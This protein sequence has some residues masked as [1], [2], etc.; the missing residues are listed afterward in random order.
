MERLDAGG[1]RVHLQFLVGLPVQG[2]ADFDVFLREVVGGDEDFADLVGVFGV[3]AL[4]EETG[5]AAL[6]GGD[7][8]AERATAHGSPSSSSNWPTS[9]A[10]KSWNPQPIPSVSCS[11][12]A[13]RARNC[14]YSSR[15]S[16]RNRAANSPKADSTLV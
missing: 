8:L 2:G 14:G 5:V 6:D 1:V 4:C 12:F 16:P 10:M 7:G 13:S 15:A 9:P 3:V 11:T